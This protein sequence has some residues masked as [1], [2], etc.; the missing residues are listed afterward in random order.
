MNAVLLIEL[1]NFLPWL[2][3]TELGKLAVSLFSRSRHTHQQNFQLKQ[4]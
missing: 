2:T 1:G 3:W 4:N